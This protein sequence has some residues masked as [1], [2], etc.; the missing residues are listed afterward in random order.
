MFPL[1]LKPSASCD[2]LHCQPTR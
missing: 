2:T 1:Q